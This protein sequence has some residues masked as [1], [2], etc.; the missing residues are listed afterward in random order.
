MSSKVFLSDYIRCLALMGW[1]ISPDGKVCPRCRKWHRLNRYD[2]N[3]SKPDG[4]EAHC[5]PCVS[6]RK[7]IAKR[8]RQRLERR[9]D[10]FESVIV[11]SLMADGPNRFAEIFGSALKEIVDDTKTETTH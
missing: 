8:Q 5:K 2:R 4:R 7:R 3:K 1:D 6:H 9:T 10:K 11:G